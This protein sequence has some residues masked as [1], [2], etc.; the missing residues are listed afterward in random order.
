MALLTTAARHWSS[1]IS[2][3]RSKV[4]TAASI[5]SSSGKSSNCIVGTTLNPTPIILTGLPDEVPTSSCCDFDGCPLFLL[6]T[7]TTVATSAEATSLATGGGTIPTTAEIASLRLPFQA[8]HELTEP[9]VHLQKDY[10]KAHVELIYIDIAEERP[11]AYKLTYHLN[12][13]IPWMT[14]I[15]LAIREWE[16]YT[17][18]G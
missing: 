16:V 3:M 13:P 10:Y 8:L 9:R 14:R 7:G 2:S 4:G 17:T 5:P 15:K 1:T 6:T 12:L 18:I 11:K